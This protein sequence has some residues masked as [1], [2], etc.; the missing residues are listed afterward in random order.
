[1]T[2]GV[3]GLMYFFSA[4]SGSFWVVCWWKSVAVRSSRSLWR[5][6]L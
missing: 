6:C 5:F 2:A 4:S 3:R 1:M